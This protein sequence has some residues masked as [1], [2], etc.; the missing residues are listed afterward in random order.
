MLYLIK[1]QVQF[2]SMEEIHVELFWS[3][4]DYVLESFDY[5]HAT[6]LNSHFG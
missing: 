2:E 6:G 3:F 1:K 4:S 5:H